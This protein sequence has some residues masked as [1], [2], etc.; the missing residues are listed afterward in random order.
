MKIIKGRINWMEGYGNTPMLELLVDKIP[1]QSDLR[2]SMHNN[3]YYAE[4][5]GYVRFYWWEGPHNN[6][7]YGGTEFKITMVDGKDVIL[8]GPWSSNSSSVNKAGFGPCIEVALFD[9]LT[10]YQS[11]QAYYGG[12]VTIQLLN[13]Y[14]DVIEID[15]SPLNMAHNS[16][17]Q[18]RDM[19]TFPPNSKVTIKLVSQG[20]DQYRYEQY[21]PCIVFPDGTEYMKP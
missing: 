6:R 2:Y 17:D 14:L 13:Q 8:K 19:V 4:L 12:T 7:G 1:H 20:N 16:S 5:D 9:N 11:N 10:M 21:V 3:I 18:C 15:T